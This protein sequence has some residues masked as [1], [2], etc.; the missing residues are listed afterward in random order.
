MANG[1]IFFRLCEKEVI[2]LLTLYRH[3]KVALSYARS[4]NFFAFFME[5]G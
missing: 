1:L 3:Q 4:N 5:Q 2:N